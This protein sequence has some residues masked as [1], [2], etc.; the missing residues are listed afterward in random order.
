MTDLDISYVHNCEC[1]TVGPRAARC[2]VARCSDTWSD[3][4]KTSANRDPCRPPHLHNHITQRIFT[5]TIASHILETSSSVLAYSFIRAAQLI[6]VK[7]L[8]SSLPQVG[9]IEQFASHGANHATL[10]GCMQD[11]LARSCTPL[12][13]L[14]TIDLMALRRGTSR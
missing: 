6:P 1:G 8:R 3:A 14:R 2:G 10:N 4:R 12:S 7:K 13:P 5:R 11:L 9:C